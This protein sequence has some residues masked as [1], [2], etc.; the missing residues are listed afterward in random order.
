MIHEQGIKAAETEAGNLS[1]GFLEYQARRNFRDL[2]RVFGF[3]G[4]RQIIAEII[5][6]EAEKAGRYRDA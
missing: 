5:N 1:A 3:G 4:A 2:C 6:D